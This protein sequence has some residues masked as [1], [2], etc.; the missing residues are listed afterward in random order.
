M[1][2]YSPSGGQ[3]DQLLHWWLLVHF[4]PFMGFER[5]VFFLPNAPFFG[6]LDKR[7]KRCNL[8]NINTDLEQLALLNFLQRLGLGEDNPKLFIDCLWCNQRPH[9]IKNANKQISLGENL[10]FIWCH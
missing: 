9:F 4:G 10:K 7:C 2:I 6:Y 3:N 8:T 1:K 5:E